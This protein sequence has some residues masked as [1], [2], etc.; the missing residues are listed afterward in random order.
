MIY[1]VLYMNGLAQFFNE[2][3][4]DAE[5]DREQTKWQSWYANTGLAVFI[6]KEREPPA[7]RNTKELP[8]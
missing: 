4:S 2:F 5:A 6:R 8:A 1:V 3:A 7:P